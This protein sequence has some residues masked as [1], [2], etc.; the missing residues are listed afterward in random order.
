MNHLIPIDQSI[1]YVKKIR[2]QAHYMKN[3]YDYMK[4]NCT[5]DKITSTHHLEASRNHLEVPHLKNGHSLQ[6]WGGTDPNS[7]SL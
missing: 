6:K 3:N 2:G 4:N 1:H 7:L 5:I